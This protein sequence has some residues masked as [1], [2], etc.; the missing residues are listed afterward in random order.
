MSTPETFHAWAVVE[1]MGHRKL[2]GL[3]TSP[4]GPGALAGMLRIDVCEAMDVILDEEPTP[5]VNALELL[6]ELVG[7]TTL[8]DCEGNTIHGAALKVVLAMTKDYVEASQSVT[9][10]VVHLAQGLAAEYP[11]DGGETIGTR[12]A[13]LRIA[14][15]WSLDELARHSKISRGYIWKIESGQSTNPSLYKIKSLA[16]AL[17]CAAGYLAEAA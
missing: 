3:V 9:E 14:R 13:R 16:L 7:K 8:P 15:R 1:V 11:V 4:G 17:G 5:E 10:A 2:A 12:V 6:L